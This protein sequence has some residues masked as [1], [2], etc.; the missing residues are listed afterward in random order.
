MRDH[1]ENER[2]AEEE[3]ERITTDESRRLEYV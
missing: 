1:V 2:G 3:H